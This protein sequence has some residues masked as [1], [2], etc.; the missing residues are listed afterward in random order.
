MCSLHHRG[1]LDSYLGTQTFA[2]GKKVSN[3][4]ESSNLP[5]GIIKN[6]KPVQ[7][8]SLTLKYMLYFSSG[9]EFGR[10]VEFSDNERF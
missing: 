10:Y 1:T 8:P 6:I 5:F 4:L 2:Y 9:S 3:L 7:I